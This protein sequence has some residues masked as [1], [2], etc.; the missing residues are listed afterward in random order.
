MIA[1]VGEKR[2]GEEAVACL[3]LHPDAVA[4]SYDPAAIFGEV[5]DLRAIGSRSYKVAAADVAETAGVRRRS[6]ADP[7]REE[8]GRMV[9]VEGTPEAFLELERLL[10]EP[11][12]TISDRFRAEVSR[13]ERFDLL[14]PEERVVGFPADWTK[15][16]VELTFHP[17]SYSES[18]QLSF[19][20]ELL[21]LPEQVR[22]T[23]RVKRYERGPTFV[24]CRLTRE[25]VEVCG[26]VNL[27]RS[28]HPLKFRGLPRSS[29]SKPGLAP[30]PPTG[31]APSGLILGVIDGG[32][33]VD[34]PVFSGNVEVDESASVSTPAHEDCVEHGEAVSAAASFG[35]LNNHPRR[36][37]LPRP[38][39][40]IRHARVFPTTDPDDLDLY[41]AVDCVEKFVKNNPDAQVVNL[42]F[43]PEG[44]IEEGVVSRF[45]YALDRLRDRLFVVAVG[46]DGD[47]GETLGRIQ[48][49]ADSVNSI[50]VGAVGLDGEP[51]S[52]S[53]RGYGREGGKVQPLV[54][55]VGGDDWEKMRLY[56]RGR[57]FL[58][59][60]TSFA[61]PQV[62]AVAT[63]IVGGVA[64]GTP[65]LAQALLTH[66]AKHVGDHPDRQIG[67]GLCPPDLRDIL[68]CDRKELTL[69]Y[70]GEISSTKYLK[71]PIPLKSG[72]GIRGKVHFR[73]TVVSRPEVDAAH[74]YDYTTAGVEDTFYPDADRY[75][76]ERPQHVTSGKKSKTLS[77]TDDA[78]EVGRLL[79]AGWKQGGWPVSNSSNPDDEHHQRLGY[80]WDTVV[81]HKVRKQASKVREPF[82]TLHGMSRRDWSGEI[83]YA[84][85]VTVEA[86]G[87][88]ASR[89]LYNEARTNYPALAP[90][91]LRAN[92]R[93]F[94][95]VGG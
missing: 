55:A 82:I 29:P 46:N 42:S 95:S 61:A 20:F 50:G 93:N 79:A 28:V 52:Y 70:Q 88:P 32:I 10:D 19:L 36:T 49:P 37:P 30:K 85:V 53:C 58:D 77:L 84:V 33:D 31:C 69:V 12:D 78:E 4:K 62:A 56:G 66:A 5:R 47:L 65:I 83:P 15:G 11:P 54:A 59:A 26:T 9:F 72:E 67:Y 43:G 14:T 1:A 51:A 86:P 73:W 64:G 90:V 91:E 68:M 74:P 48:S 3:R 16:R 80:K 13:A 41:E 45:T 6:G 39:V 21:D 76:F 81:R 34:D 8:T 71:L 60:G 75:K 94:V 2:I 92:I 17:S 38:R 57:T 24:S 87:L 23:A 89:D 7:A 63:Q 25:Q 22:A 18:R 40:R 44:P 35:P 27:L